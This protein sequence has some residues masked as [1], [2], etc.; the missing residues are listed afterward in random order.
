VVVCLGAK[1]E[2]FSSGTV[3]LYFQNG[4]IEDFYSL[5]SGPLY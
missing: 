1:V 3:V 5:K 4:N 2:T